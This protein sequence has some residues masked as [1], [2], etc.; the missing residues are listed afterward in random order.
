MTTCLGK[1]CS[2][3]LPS[4]VNC[5]HFM[6]L[7]ISLLVLRAVCGILLYQFLI[8]AYLFTLDTCSVRRGT[9]GGGR[10][11]ERGAGRREKGDREK[12]EGRRE[13][14]REGEGRKGEGEGR[15]GEG[16]GRKGGRE[17]GERGREKGEGEKGEGEKEERDPPVAPS[18]M[19]EADACLKK[20]NS[21]KDSKIWRM[22][23]GPI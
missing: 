2:F 23:F 9:G 5:C 19:P 3:C 4:F 10:A 20:N 13:K 17:K 22:P 6:Y 8:S 12:G 16:E 11:G 7:V 14:R 15:K 21:K 18:S 1:S